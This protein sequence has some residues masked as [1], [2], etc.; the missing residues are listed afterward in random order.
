MI[1]LVYHT[2]LEFSVPKLQRTQEFIWFNGAPKPLHVHIESSISIT[3]PVNNVKPLW[4]INV[5][6]RGKI[7]CRNRCVEFIES[8]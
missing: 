6:R 8:G 7:E 1:I 5:C 3:E 4:Q 2:E